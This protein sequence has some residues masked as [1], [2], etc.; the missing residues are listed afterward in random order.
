MAPSNPPVWLRGPVA[1]VP[2]ALQPAAHALLEVRED[3]RRTVAPMSREVLH[4][5]P[6]GAASVAFH[7]FHLAGALDR[8]F[9][10]ARGTPLDDAQLAA[11]AAERAGVDPGLDAETLVRLV[12]TTVDRA[13]AQLRAT[14]ETSLFDERRVGRAGSPSNVLGLLLHGAEHSARHLGQIVTTAKIVASSRSG[15]DSV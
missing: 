11:L 14:P 12:E 9:T 10:Y 7:L 15:T 4:T 8:L 3:V 2:A 5:R 13:L 1:G 6:G